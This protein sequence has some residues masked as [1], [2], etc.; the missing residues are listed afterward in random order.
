MNFCTTMVHLIIPLFALLRN[1]FHY[2]KERMLISQMHD[3]THSQKGTQ[4][5][6]Q[7]VEQK[8]T[9]RVTDYTKIPGI[10]HCLNV[11]CMILGNK[12]GSITFL[13]DAYRATIVTLIWP[14]L[15]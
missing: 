1:D 13:K 12:Q 9:S 3:S 5:E 6:P 2:A 8:C 11:I 14:E 7:H 15:S 10:K 4:Y